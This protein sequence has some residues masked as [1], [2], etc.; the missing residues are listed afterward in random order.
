MLID[1]AGLSIEYRM[2]GQA[3]RPVV[4][5][6]HSLATNL[7]LWNHQVA[8][9]VERFQV[10]SY[11]VRGHGGSEVPPAPYSF[12][13]L[14]GDVRSLIESLGIDSV[15]FVGI[16]LGGTIGQQF[17]L[18]HPERV[19]SLVICSSTSYT[20][21]KVRLIWDQRIAVAELQ[22]ME[23]HV[24]PTTGRWFTPTFFRDRADEVERIKQM[25][26]NTP[27][28]G[29]VGCARALQ[30]VDLRNRLGNIRARTL[31]IAAS[32]DRGT[33]PEMAAEMAARIP[34]SELRVLKGASHMCN[35]EQFD[36]F[37]GRLLAFLNED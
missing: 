29:Y 27:L 32:K 23:A 33:T 10:L 24:E 35:V 30:N 13:M 8:P 28:E 5:L 17:A 37:N 36:A 19:K 16:S 34:R 7:T 26:R 31:V 14:A 22:G 12:S 4:I 6:S 18:D 21:P 3:G 1:A 9:L 11:D 20:P 25:I 15:H 2:A